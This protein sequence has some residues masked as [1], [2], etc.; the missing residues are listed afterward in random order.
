MS[1]L[2]GHSFQGFPGCWVT[3]TLIQG[4]TAKKMRENFCLRKQVMANTSRD[5]VTL[6][7]FTIPTRLST[8]SVIYRIVLTFERQVGKKRALRVQLPKLL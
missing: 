7:Y 6:I 8:P 1:W 3:S 5:L 2:L 4:Q